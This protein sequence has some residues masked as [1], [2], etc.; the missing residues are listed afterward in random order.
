MF[1][2]SAVQGSISKAIRTGGQ[3]LEKIGRT[4]EMNAYVEKREF[5][6]PHFLSPPRGL[7]FLLNPLVLLP[8]SSATLGSRHDTREGR[9]GY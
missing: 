6:E 9:S 3:A 7:L 2:L 5:E 4:M 1:S 8:S